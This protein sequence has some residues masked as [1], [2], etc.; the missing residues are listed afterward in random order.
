MKRKDVEEM[1]VA[2]I[3]HADYDLAK[4]LDPETAEDPDDA[5]D[6]LAHLVDIASGWI[7]LDD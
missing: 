3:S 1:I 5:N 7:A 6:F 2:I 4:Q